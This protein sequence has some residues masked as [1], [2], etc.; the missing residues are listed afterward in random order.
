MKIKIFDLDDTLITSPARCKVYDSVTKKSQFLSPSQFNLF[1]PQSYHHFSF[2][3]FDN[4]A[5]LY[6]ADF[7]PL[8][9]KFK[10][11]YENEEALGIVTARS[12]TILLHEFFLSKGFDLDIDLIYATTHPFHNFT[13]SVAQRKKQAFEKLIQRGFNEFE[14]YDDNI[15]NLSL[16]KSLELERDVKIHAFHV[17]GKTE[18]VYRGE[19]KGSHHTANS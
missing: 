6:K 16:V 5:I 13:G 3:E 15:E 10:D 17:D 12:N 9:E 18:E 7:L 4:R 14:F 1:V 11:I 2:E 8:F 19:G